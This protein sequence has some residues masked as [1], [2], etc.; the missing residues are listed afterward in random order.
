V[1]RFPDPAFADYVGE[2]FQPLGVYINFFQPRLIAGTER[3]FQI[4]MVN[5]YADAMRGSLV[6]TLENEAGETVTRAERRFELPAG[7]DASYE[8]PL[9]IPALAGKCTLKATATPDGDGQIDATVSR[10]WVLVEE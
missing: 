3:T 1:G 10:R 4:M 7:G 2:A 5:D 9:S 8:L 6:L